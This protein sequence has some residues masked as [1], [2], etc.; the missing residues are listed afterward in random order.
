M[1]L[2][3]FNIF[4]KI[5][6]WCKH[7]LPSR[8]SR[9]LCPVLFAA[10]LACYFGTFVYR[11]MSS[12]ADITLERPEDSLHFLHTML[13][14]RAFSLLVLICLVAVFTLKCI[15]VPLR[16]SCE[17]LLQL[18]FLAQRVQH[19]FRVFNGASIPQSRMRGLSI[20]QSLCLFGVH[21]NL[22]HSP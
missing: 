18:L 15:R 12:P 2:R 19:F 9:T 4:S 13:L 10:A 7:S 21:V 20:P 11:F 22:R 16:D 6:C 8:Q 5:F 1:I 14:H 3:F 17:L